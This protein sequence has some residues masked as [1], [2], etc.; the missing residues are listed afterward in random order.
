VI[1]ADGKPAQVAIGQPMLLRACVVGYLIFW[2][3]TIVW[4]MVLGD[5]LSS[6]AV[7]LV[8]IVF[9][10]AIGYRVFRIGVRSG[11]DGTLTIRNNHS[12]RRLT[13][14]EIEDF[15]FGGSGGLGQQSIHALLRDGTV[16]RMDVT[17]TALGLGRKRNAA[18]L[19]TLRAWLHSS[20]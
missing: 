18:G 17:N 11:P 5:R 1:Q 10:L 8:F 4:T 3:A 16:Y 20:A 2:T 9:G 19:R 14:A 12:T 15:R 6:A 13:R 7:G